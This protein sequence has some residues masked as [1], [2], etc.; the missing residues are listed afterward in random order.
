MMQQNPSFQ[1]NKFLAYIRSTIFF[2]G[3]AITTLVIAPLMIILYPVSTYVFRYRYCSGCWVT[4]V[5]WMLEHICGLGFR[6]EGLENI[7]RQAAIIFSKHQSAWETIALQ[8]IFPPLVFILKREV[9]W[10]PFFGWALATCEPISINR[11]SK[12]QAL[13]QVIHQGKERLEAGRWVVIFPE[14]TRVAPG[15]KKKYSGGG[16]LL[17][18]QTGCPVVPV[19]HNAGEFWP[20]KSFLKFP[21]LIQ[22]KIG[23]MIESKDKSAS[24]INQEAEAWIERQMSEIKL[25]GNYLDCP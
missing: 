22:V 10:I 17:A 3:M 15:Q 21:G 12:R 24:Q 11:Q 18:H 4:I 19:A 16:G 13:R 25:A 23:P 20:R 5:L 1:A 14:G 8:K 9:L 2:F 7:P 6:V